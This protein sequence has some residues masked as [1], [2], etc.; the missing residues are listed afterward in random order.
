M[1]KEANNIQ[2]LTAARSLCISLIKRINQQQP[3]SFS[4]MNKK[5]ANQMISSKRATQKNCK[6]SSP[7]GKASF[8]ECREFFD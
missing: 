7:N 3:K 1:Q 8:I 5:N 6:Q 2:E 4:Q